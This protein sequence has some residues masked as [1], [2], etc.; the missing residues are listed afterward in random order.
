MNVSTWKIS[1][2]P[3]KEL[4]KWEKNLSFHVPYCLKSQGLDKRAVICMSCSSVLKRRR[5]LWPPESCLLT[6]LLR[7]PAWWRHQ[8][9]KQRLRSSKDDGC[10]DCYRGACSWGTCSVPERPGQGT[11]SLLAFDG[12]HL[13]PAWDSGFIPATP[14]P[15]TLLVRTIFSQEEGWKP[16]SRKVIS[17]GS[18]ARSCRLLA[19]GPGPRPLGSLSVTVAAA[20]LLA[21]LP[22]LG[23]TDWLAARQ[24]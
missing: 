1:G 14:S 15:G 10:L 13:G 6:Q 4:G 9:G 23:G 12:Q 18:W 8:D 2:Q 7:P 17:L 5:A 22:L 19:P 20:G 11:F 16:C 3:H 21:P 24:Q